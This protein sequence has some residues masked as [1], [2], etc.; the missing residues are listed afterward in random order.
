MICS[1]SN[2]KQIQTISDEI[3]DR[4]KAEG[5]RVIS[6][7]GYQHGEWILMDFGDMIVHV[8]SEQARSYYELERLWRD[9]KAVPIPADGE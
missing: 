3:A 1:G 9:A 5:D 6:V 8:F 2:S 4:M 7:E